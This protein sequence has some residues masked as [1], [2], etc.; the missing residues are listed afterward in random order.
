MSVIGKTRTNQPVINEGDLVIDNDVTIGGDVNADG[1]YGNEIIENMSGYSYSV[2]T[3]EGVTQTNSYV[4][5]VKNGNK[6]TFAIVGQIT[7]T[8][9]DPIAGDNKGLGAFTIPTAVAN[10][11]VPHTIG[12]QVNVLRTQPISLANRGYNIKHTVV[13]GIYKATDTSISMSMYGIDNFTKDEVLD[14]AFEV[15]F[16]LSDNLIS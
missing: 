16:L 1:I 9:D 8:T 2:A 11:L 6:I 14:F 7:K 12:S 13:V 15:T 3:K 4:G 5:V 10:K